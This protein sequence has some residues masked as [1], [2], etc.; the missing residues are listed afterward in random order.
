MDGREVGRGGR[1]RQWNRGVT[2][3]RVMCVVGQKM[4]AGTRAKIT[5]LPPF[6]LLYYECL[7]R[8]IKKIL[9]QRLSFWIP[10]CASVGVTGRGWGGGEE[11]DGKLGETQDII[12]SSSV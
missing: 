11:E 12:F 10:V 7:K 5:S 1:R 6:Y 3:D 4:Y 2:R 9:H 8:I